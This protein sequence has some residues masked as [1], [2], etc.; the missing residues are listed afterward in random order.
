MGYDVERQKKYNQKYY[1][2]HK[3]DSEFKKQRNEYARKRYL[4][5]KESIDA[6]NKKWNLENK[7]KMRIYQRSWF[8]NKRMVDPSFR[9]KKLIN[10]RVCRAID[11][12]GKSLHQLLPYSFVELKN[13]LEKQFTNKMSWDNHGIYWHIDHIIPLSWFKTPEQLIKY[14][15]ALKNLQPLEHELNRKKNDYYIGNPKTH[16]GVIY[17]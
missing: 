16:I 17:L 10:A 4:K 2:E 3:D 5:N 7:E 15:W 8:K 14:G 13:H 1:S 12:Q 9:I 11:K 6:Q